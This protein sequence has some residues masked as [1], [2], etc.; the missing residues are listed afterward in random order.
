MGGEGSSQS[1][2]CDD[3]MRMT[4]LG[5][6]NAMPLDEASLVK[7]AQLQSPKRM[8]GVR[9]TN[10]RMEASFCDDASVIIRKMVE[11]PRTINYVGPE[12]RVILQRPIT[13]GGVQHLSL[14]SL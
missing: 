11:A 6:V 9:G 13:L 10:H 5:M 4:N 1:P 3:P 14:T 12:T 7:N 8:R 2:I